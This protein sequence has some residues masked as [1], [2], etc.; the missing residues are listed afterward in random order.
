MLWM[1]SSDKSVLGVTAPTPRPTIAGGL[2]LASL[3]TLP[4]AILVGAIYLMHWLL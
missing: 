4:V 2:W 3:M 1:K